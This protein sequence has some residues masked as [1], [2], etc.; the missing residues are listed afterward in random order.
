MTENEART[1]WCP[2]YRNTELSGR[3][4]NRDDPGMLADDSLFT[5]YPFCLASSCMMWRWEKRSDYTMFEN[6]GNISIQRTSYG[7]CG[8]GGKL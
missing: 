8:L 1:K 6:D 7:Y 5:S 4:T 2:M 3:Q